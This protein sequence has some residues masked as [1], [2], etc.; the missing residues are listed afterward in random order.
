LFEVDNCF[1]L[2]E[3]ADYFSTVPAVL[4]FIEENNTPVS[5]WIGIDQVIQERQYDEVGMSWRRDCVR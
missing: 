3:P 5:N 4:M 1:Y 2:S